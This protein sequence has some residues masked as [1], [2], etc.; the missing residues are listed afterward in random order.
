VFYP[1]VFRFFGGQLTIKQNI[2]LNIIQKIARKTFIY[3]KQHTISNHYR[4][5]KTTQ[6][7]GTLKSIVKQIFLNGKKQKIKCNIRSKE[8]SNGAAT[9]LRKESQTLLP[10]TEK[11][12]KPQGIR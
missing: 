2:I 4:K 9:P 8:C 1:C 5:T 7:L 12:I 6:I 11:Q 10:V 3:S